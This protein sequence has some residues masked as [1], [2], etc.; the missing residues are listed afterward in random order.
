MFN[1]SAAACV[2]QCMQMQCIYV[3]EL[4]AEREYYNIYQTHKMPDGSQCL[5]IDVV[6]SDNVVA[7]CWQCF[8][9]AGDMT[10]A[11][12][13]AKLKEGHLKALSLNHSLC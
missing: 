12:I 13:I 2:C 9:V 10:A 7:C 5:S 11:K 1:V 4:Q 8:V 3:C 6:A